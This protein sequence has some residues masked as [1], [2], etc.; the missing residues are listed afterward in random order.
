MTV[1]LV[2]RL[3]GSLPASKDTEAALGFLKQPDII[4]IAPSGSEVSFGPAEASL[5]ICRIRQQV[6][7]EAGVTTYG[8]PSLLSAL[9]K[10]HPAEL[11]TA[12]AF[13]TA[14]W[15]GT[16]LLDNTDR[17]V[18]FVLVKRR[19]PEEEQERLDWFRR[20]LT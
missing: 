1:E 12:A 13:T 10:L 8:F 4:R 5:R 20:N 15:Y 9:A 6:T 7:T 3:I 11:V 19:S 18:G 17:L 14:D 16:F 2:A